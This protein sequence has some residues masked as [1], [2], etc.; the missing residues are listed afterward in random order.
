MT[1]V[2]LAVTCLIVAAVSL[3]LARRFQR[4]AEQLRRRHES[5]E[6]QLE[7]LHARVESSERAAE[8]WPGV[9]Q[10][11]LR[12][13]ERS[14]RAEI[15]KVVSVELARANREASLAAIKGGDVPAAPVT[16]EARIHS[17]DN[18]D[19]G[20]D[21]RKRKATLLDS[22][23][24][25][26]MVVGAEQVVTVGTSTGSWHV[27]LL[28]SFPP[29]RTFASV[30]DDLVRALSGV[31]AGVSSSAAD[32][33]AAMFAAAVGSRA[34]L[35]LGPL[36]ASAQDDTVKAA[37]LTAEEFADVSERGVLADPHEMRLS[38]ETLEPARIL[39]LDLHPAREQ[40]I[41]R[42]ILDDFM[43]REFDSPVDRDWDIPGPFDGPEGR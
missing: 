17:P 31:E 33:L 3:G 27:H 5:V 15:T 26:A 9:F 18:L 22:A 36:L 24:A 6:K 29:G 2:V 8:R 38:L 41:V 43:T 14:L 25:S 16:F 30:R 20:E 4:D 7:L 12:E 13:H 40:D 11:K 34:T 42:D 23:I 37:V 35:A 1:G 39:D 21:V 10:D 32:S 28:V 19:D